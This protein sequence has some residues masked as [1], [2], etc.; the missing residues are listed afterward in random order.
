VSADSDSVVWDSSRQADTADSSA[1][2]EEQ[3]WLNALEAGDLDENGELKRERD[4]SI[5]TARQVSSE[6]SQN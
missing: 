6:V 4:P 2:D 1:D 5:L 3:E